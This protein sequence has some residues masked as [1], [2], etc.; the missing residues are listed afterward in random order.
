MFASE[1]WIKQVRGHCID[2]RRQET[3]RSANGKCETFSPVVRVITGVN[4]CTI[5][6][7][8]KVNCVCLNL[9]VERSTGESS[10]GYSSKGY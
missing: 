4:S 2:D 8:A 9:L 1:D 7:Q 6:L 3:A 10:M 5:H